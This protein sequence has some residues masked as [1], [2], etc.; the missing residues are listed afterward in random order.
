MT[1]FTARQRPGGGQ[2]EVRAA[3]TAR[4]VSLQNRMPL[5]LVEQYEGAFPAILVRYFSKMMID[6]PVVDQRAGMLGGTARVTRHPIGVVAAVAPWNV[7]QG[8]T[9]LELAP[10]L[11]AGCTVALKPAEETVLDA[12]LMCEAAAAAD[13]PPGVLNVVPGGREIGAYLVERPGVDKVSFTGSTSAGSKIAETSE[14]YCARSP[15]NSAASR[16][17]FCSMTST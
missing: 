1:A 13:L 9:F 8:I 12:S 4:R 2:L 7:P 3:E 15:W 11:A 17:L 14:D 10:A 16:P 6:S 5:W